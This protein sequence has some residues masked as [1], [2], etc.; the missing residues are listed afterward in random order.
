MEKQVGWPQHICDE[1]K[2]LGLAASIVP[3][4]PYSVSGATMDVINKGTAGQVI[5]I[6]N[7]ETAAEDE[8]FK[9]GAG[10]F[11]RMYTTFDNP[12]SPFPVSGRSSLQTWLPHFTAGQT[13]LS[14]HNTFIKE[15]DILFAK[16]HE[17]Q[18]GMRVVYSLCPNANWY[19]EGTLPPADLLI[20]HDCH[21]VLGTD[22]Y[23]SNWQLSIASEIKTLKDHYP[24]L[25]LERLLQWGTSNG[26][27]ALR[28]DELGSFE[29][30]KR[31]GAVL[32]KPDFRSERVI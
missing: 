28:W 27:K 10:D 16:E 11:I 32:V 25:E 22:S 18:Y 26:A 7:Q 21:V 19:I 30:G 2:R 4:A 15:A 20:K 29:K 24:H 23:S 6:H 1:H 3:H 12:G 13:I 8:L 17:A 14:V 9:T 5:S 31:P